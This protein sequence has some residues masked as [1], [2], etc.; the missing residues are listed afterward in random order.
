MRSRTGANLFQVLLKDR[1][2][3]IGKAVTRKRWAKSYP[4]TFWKVT[5]FAP[6]RLVRAVCQ[7]CGVV[8]CG[9]M[10]VG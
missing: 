4:G 1:E 10:D 7:W 8:S 2:F 5:D 6:N 9:V 3:G